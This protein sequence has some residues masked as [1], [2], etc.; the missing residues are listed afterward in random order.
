[1]LLDTIY[2]DVYHF[3]HGDFSD[4][5]YGQRDY[6]LATQYPWMDRI[7]CEDDRGLLFWMDTD[8]FLYDVAKNFGKV[9]NDVNRAN[10]L[11]KG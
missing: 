5:S 8:N 9:K 4:R 3:F 2:V 11:M 7:I 6:I 10:D 1:M